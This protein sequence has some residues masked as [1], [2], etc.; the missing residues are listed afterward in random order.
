MKDEIPE[1]KWR[2]G[3]F[4]CVD[5]VL[6]HYSSSLLW[7]SLCCPWILVGQLM[8]RSKLNVWGCRSQDH[9]V[10]MT[11][12]SGGSIGS[13]GSNQ[14]RGNHKHTFYLVLLFALFLLNVV[15]TLAF[16]SNVYYSSQPSLSLLYY[17]VAFSVF[18]YSIIMLIYYNFA[19][20]ST[21][22]QGFTLPTVLL[23]DHHHTTSGSSHNNG[24]N[25]STVHH[26]S[27]RS[28]TSSSQHPS[29]HL[30]CLDDCVVSTFCAVCSLIQISRHTHDESFYQYQCCT[31][32]G[33]SSDAPDV[34]YI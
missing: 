9:P 8:Q 11:R 7:V 2:H 16:L 17:N 13:I 6:S 3:L 22:R 26:A 15:I 19:I 23:P 31:K 18:S 24:S 27:S 28:T 1:G 34:Y 25:N 5:V 14:G 4:S 30:G 29:H 12:S 20:R 21:I 32:R 33:I 10:V